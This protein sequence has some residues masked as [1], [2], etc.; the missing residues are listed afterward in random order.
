MSFYLSISAS[1]FGLYIV[2]NLWAMHSHRLN[3]PAYVL[4]EFDSVVG[5]RHNSLSRLAAGF[6][7]FVEK[8][9]IRRI[10]VT[11]ECLTLFT[12]TNECVEIWLCDEYLSSNATY[13]KRLFPE[14]EFVRMPV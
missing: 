5:V 12:D 6:T 7:T 11:R 14:A 3:Q 2:M 13:A 10:Q 1:L 9:H 8:H 4:T